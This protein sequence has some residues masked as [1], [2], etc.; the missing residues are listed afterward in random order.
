VRRGHRGARVE[1]HLQLQRCDRHGERR[2]R[3]QPEPRARSSVPERRHGHVPGP[4][5]S[6]GPDL[7][8]C[9]LSSMR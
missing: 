4:A 1:E 6:A 5:S 2:G 3:E 8:G 9:A 7:S